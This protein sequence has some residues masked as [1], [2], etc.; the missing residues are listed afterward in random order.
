MMIRQVTVDDV[1]P[2][3]GRNVIDFGPGMNVIY[4]RNGT[5]KSV[6]FQ[7]MR[8]WSQQV[9]DV[10][11]LPGWIEDA[12]DNTGAWCNVPRMVMEVEDEQVDAGAEC[13]FVDDENAARLEQ[14]GSVYVDDDSF[15][16]AMLT[17]RF[18][19]HLARMGCNFRGQRGR[20]PGVSVQ[21]HTFA[22]VGLNG[23]P[24]SVRVLA[25]LALVLAYRDVRSPRAP[26]VID[27]GGLGMLDREHRMYITR[28][29]TGLDGQVVL[30]TSVRDVARQLGI[31]HELVRSPRARGVRVVRRDTRR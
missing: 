12:T 25:A 8:A 28:E 5:G 17:V 9:D 21:G 16:F 1:S 4:G 27:D 26:L 30:F 2:F 20:S 31:G 29:L 19:N 24:S 18:T 14:G 13:F 15:S 11:A 23:A 10:F 3:V 22:L 7:G 6:L